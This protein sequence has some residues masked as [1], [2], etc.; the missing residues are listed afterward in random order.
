[1]ATAKRP[2]ARSW[3]GV[4]RR[5]AEWSQARVHS[6]ALR[7][8]FECFVLPMSG[9]ASL[10]LNCA[11]RCATCLRDV[12]RAVTRPCQTARR[13]RFG[14][15]AKTVDSLQADGH[16]GR[17]D[18]TAGKGVQGPCVAAIIPTLLL[19]HS[20]LHLA[21]SSHTMPLVHIVLLKVKAD[22]WDAGNGKAELVS[23]LE[24]LKEVRPE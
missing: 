6:I 2:S 14:G 17:S 21:N 15:R 4:A 9:V 22:I 13:A 24:G 16:V 12:P 20:H 11:D 10:L 18:V 23:K 7:R 19:V 3:R 1:M 8:P 5:G